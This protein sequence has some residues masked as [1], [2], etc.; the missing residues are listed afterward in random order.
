MVFKFKKVR[1]PAVPRFNGRKPQTASEGEEILS[2][3]VDGMPAKRD[4][5]FFMLEARKLPTVKYSEFR[6]S[7]GAPR[8]VPGWLELDALVDTYSGW[9]AFE[10]DDLSFVHL[11]QRENAETMTKDL[12]RVNGL[13]K[14]GINV[15]HIE[16]VDA[17]DLKT[18][19]M[20]KDL[21]RKI[22]L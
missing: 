12:R 17:A 1:V 3:Y 8:G 6:V 9:R 14:R 13:R 20:A 2:G 16:H 15:S 7:L 4:E 5:E 10:I 19:N 11:G 21:L 18:R 22:N